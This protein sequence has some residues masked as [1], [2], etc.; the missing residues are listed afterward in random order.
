MVVTV[1]IRGR[2]RGD[3]QVAEAVPS[4]ARAVS[5]ELAVPVEDVW[6]QWIDVPSGTAF[7]GGGILD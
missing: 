7:A 4:A 6:M 1:V 5:P 2:V 3:E